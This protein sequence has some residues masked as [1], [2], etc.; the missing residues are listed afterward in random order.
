MVQSFICPAV[1]S[2]VTIDIEIP[3]KNCQV[4]RRGLMVIVKIIQSL[5]NNMFFGKEPHMTILNNFLESNIANIT[6]F[7]SE[8]HVCSSLFCAIDTFSLKNKI[9]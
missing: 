7:L 1:V 9:K 8:M 5:A 4:L 6:R 3:K 2:P